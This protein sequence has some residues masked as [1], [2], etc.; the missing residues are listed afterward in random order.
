MK[1]MGDYCHS[2]VY[3]VNSVSW[4]RVTT[5]LSEFNGHINRISMVLGQIFEH[6]HHDVCVCVGSSMCVHADT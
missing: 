6:A 4:G 3:G 1:R 5:N 2:T